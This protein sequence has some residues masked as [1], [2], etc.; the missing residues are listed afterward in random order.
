METTLLFLELNNRT[1]LTEQRYAS[2]PL[3]YFLSI[4]LVVLFCFVLFCF[5]LFCFVLF[6]FV[7]FCFVLFCFVLSCLV[8]SCFHSHYLTVVCLFLLLFNF[9]YFYIFVYFYFKTNIKLQRFEG[10]HVAGYHI[11]CSIS[12]GGDVVASG[13]ADGCLYFYDWNGASIIKIIQVLIKIRRK[14]RK[15]K[16]E[17]RKQKEKNKKRK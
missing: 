8:L 3:F 12:P 10:H 2:L 13:S 4:S 15:R 14:R 6:C 1:N 11:G 16:K 17:R 5:V 9:Y 7:L